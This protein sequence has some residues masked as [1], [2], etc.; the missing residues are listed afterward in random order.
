M[1]RKRRK[2]TIAALVKMLRARLLLENRDRMSRDDAFRAAQ[3]LIDTFI[4]CAFEDG[5]STNFVTGECGAFTRDQ[6]G[7]ERAIR[8][9]FL[10]RRR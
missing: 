10:E 1:A 9:E 4:V 3:S 7:V 8:N 2:P 5:Y 6:V